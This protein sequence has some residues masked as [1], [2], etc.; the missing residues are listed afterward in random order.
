MSAKHHPSDETL[1]RYAAGT[2]EPGPALVVATHL[3]LCPACSDKA[4]TF[5]AV[6]GA[7]LDDLPPTEMAHDA[8]DKVLSRIDAEPR[9]ASPKPAAR[10]P[11]VL[12]GFVLPDALKGCDIGPWRWRGPGVH[13]SRVVIPDAPKASVM[14]IKVGAGRRLPHHGHTGTEYTL[15]LKGSFTDD[16]VRFARGDIEEADADVKHQPVV[17]PDGECICLAAIDGHMRL[18][19]L[20]G[21]LVQ[22]FVG[23]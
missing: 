5:E 22:P 19:G 3:E 15:I 2:L 23:I 4:R 17:D 6:G 8:L 18:Q 10:R 13:M 16:G 14:L 12:D 20:I 11:A 21:R 1:L 7:M 9:H